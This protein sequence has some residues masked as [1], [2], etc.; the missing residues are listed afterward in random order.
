MKAFIRIRVVFLALI[1]LGSFSNFAQNEWGSKLIVL[2]ET[3]IAF[4]YFIEGVLH[5]RSRLKIGK[6]Y[7]EGSAFENFC[8]GF[9]FFGF[10]MKNLWFPG[11]GPVLILS[12][13]FLLLFYIV[14][15]VKFY[16]VNRSKGILLVSLLTLGSFTAV[17][18][19]IS[20][21]FKIM[22][23]PGSAM[24]YFIGF[25]FSLV[26]IAGAAKWNFDYDNKRINVLKALS[27]LKNNIILLY[28]LTFTV[29]TF[30]ILGSWGYAPRFYS[31]KLPQSIEKYRTAGDNR[32]LEK[33]N[34]VIDSYI[35][36]ERNCFENGFLK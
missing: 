23:W 6:A 21:V 27:L 12:A 30:A 25:G 15:N 4:S 24:L 10:V 31:Q 36:F 19:G 28:F 18:L 33:A 2:S 9:L 29:S 14:Q 32:S 8:L 1:I 26:M 16:R 11:S 20:I 5:L 22:H 7:N 3:L 17:I 35:D 13:F 34:K